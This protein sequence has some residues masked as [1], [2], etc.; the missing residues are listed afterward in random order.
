MCLLASL[1]HV[2]IRRLDSVESC[3]LRQLS[4]QRSPSACPGR[5]PG[6]TLAVSAARM[7]LLEDFRKYVPEICRQ[8]QVAAFI[9]LVGC[10]SRPLTVDLPALDRAAH[11]KQSA[12]VT[13]VR[14]AGAVL[15]DGAAELRHCQHNHV[16][17]SVAEVAVERRQ[18]FSDIR[19]GADSADRPDWR[20]CP[21]RRYPEIRL[22][23]RYRP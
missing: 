9:Q 3:K 22:R 11:H 5:Q 10:E 12:G 6:N 2:H 17:H 13:V 18:T 7:C 23:G 16:A 4:I 20:E 19:A 1:V 14:S 15:L 8:C 21:I